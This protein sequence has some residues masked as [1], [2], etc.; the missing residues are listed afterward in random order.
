AELALAQARVEAARSGRAHASSPRM[1][2]V[3]IVATVLVLGGAMGFVVYRQ[4]RHSAALARQ[5]ERTVA[6]SGDTEASLLQKNALSRQRI[7]KLQAELQWLKNT[8]QRLDDKARAE[9]AAQAAA[10]AKRPKR[11][12]RGRA[13]PKPKA[14]P[15]LRTKC[16]DGDPLCGLEHTLRR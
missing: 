14:A 11:P 2:V 13:R 4:T 16:A 15:V 7:A 6:R 10:A 9:S 12:G 3:A 1:L 8:K 5:V